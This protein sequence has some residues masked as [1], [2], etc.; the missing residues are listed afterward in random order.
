[1]S[2]AVV[3]SN[4]FARSV[5]LCAL[6]TTL[7]A[8]SG[9]AGAASKT[10]TING[11][12][13][14]TVA[15][16]AHYSFTPGAK[17]TV[18]SRIKFDIYNKPGWASFDGTTGRLYGTPNRNNVGTYKNITI[19]LTDWYGFVTTAPF[20]ITVVNPTATNSAPS[21]SGAAA[22]IALVGT[23]Y[24][25]TPKAT[26]SNGDRLTFSIANEPK[27]A[28]FDAATGTLSG[29]PAATDVGKYSNIKI[30]VS[31]GKSLTA[32]AAFAISVNQVAKASAGSV[33]LDWTAPT[34]NTDGT[35]LTDLAGYTVR[36]GKSPSELTQVIKVANAG[37]TSLVVDELSDGT[38][39]FA[40]S[41]FN[42][43]GVESSNS[44]VVSTNV[45]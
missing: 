31:D 45:L 28:K 18:R 9:A 7:L 33:T 44:G 17:D 38:W 32:L 35:V 25:F 36:Y 21:I 11:T 37:L 5:L 29:T 30:S 22:A 34:E 13:P 12:P 27:W 6:G 10:L 40:I 14:A 43:A 8:L 20:S 1:M 26:D 19:R 39:Y 24:R 4:A 23:A 15:V 3:R 42:H 41:S 2:T 16:N